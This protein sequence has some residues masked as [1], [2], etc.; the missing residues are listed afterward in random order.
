MTSLV[1]SW[2][3]SPVSTLSSP[4]SHTWSKG[5]GGE[6]QVSTCL[7]TMIRYKKTPMYEC[8]PNS[9]TYVWTPTIVFGTRVR[10]CAY[11]KGG[12]GKDLGAEKEWLEVSQLAFAARVR[13]PAP[14]RGARVRAPRGRAVSEGSMGIDKSRGE[15]GEGAQC[16][17]WAI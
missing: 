11:V 9:I 16:C 7:Y 3:M 2:A 6:G 4:P 15:D 12:N 14:C 8:T 1:V 5:E 13:V 17:V 10:A